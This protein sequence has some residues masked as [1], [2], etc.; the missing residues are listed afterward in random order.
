MFAVAL[1]FAALV[2]QGCPYPATSTPAPA[3]RA[4]VINDQVTTSDPATNGRLAV[5]PTANTP[6]CA[7]PDSAPE[8]T[9]DAAHYKAYPFH[10]YTGA[11]ACVSATVYRVGAGDPLQVAAYAPSFD[12]A[13]VSANYLAAVHSDALTTYQFSFTVAPNTDFEVV[14]DSAG[15]TGAYQLLVG[16]CGEPVSSADSTPPSGIVTDVSGTEPAPPAASASGSQAT[17]SEP[18]GRSNSALPANESFGDCSAS[19]GSPKDAAFIALA[20]ALSVIGRRRR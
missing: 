11:S 20:I 9:A 18:S 3:D 12:P 16:G 13:S 2:G 4:D 19:H 5:S 1:A 10:N 7:A 6:T 14:L 17:L 8:V 15:N